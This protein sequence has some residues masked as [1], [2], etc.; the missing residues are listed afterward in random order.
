LSITLI[1]GRVIQKDL[2]VIADGAHVSQLYG[3][4]PI[5]TNSA[6]PVLARVSRGF[7][8]ANSRIVVV[9]ALLAT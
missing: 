3:V 1:D 5:L 8:G 4:D 2:L 6:K 9:E 7:D